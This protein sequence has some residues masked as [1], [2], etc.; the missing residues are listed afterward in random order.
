MNSTYQKGGL[1]SLTRFATDQ[2]LIARLLADRQGCYLH[3]AGAIINGAGML[4][5]GHSDAGKSTITR[6][7]M[8]AGGAGDIQ[9]EILCDD[10]NIVRN[11]N[12][13]QSAIRNPKSQVAGGSSA[14]GVTA[15]YRKFLPTARLC[16]LFSF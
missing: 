2:I 7:L 9:V 15:M 11:G 1:S 16:T 6:L 3:S 8:D 5:V 4:F 10:R 14:P 12:L 13:P